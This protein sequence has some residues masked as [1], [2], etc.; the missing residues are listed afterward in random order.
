MANCAAPKATCASPRAVSVGANKKS[1]CWCPSGSHWADAQ[2][3][4][5]SLY[6]LTGKFAKGSCTK[7]RSGQSLKTYNGQKYCESWAWWVWFLLALAML[8][9][10]LLLSLV[11]YGIFLLCQKICGCCRQKKKA[12]KKP[13]IK[14]VE[15]VVYS[16]PPPRQEVVVVQQPACRVEYGEPRITYGQSTVNEYREH[17]PSHMERRHVETRQLSPDR[18]HD[19][20]YNQPVDWAKESKVRYAEPSRH[21]TGGNVVSHSSNAGYNPQYSHLNPFHS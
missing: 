18:H 4:P 17:V 7:C 9:G 16:K 19:V 10:F 5:N 21:V 6:C 12:E 14:E 3:K 2:C 13:L 1:G 8:V 11:I 20:T 15:T